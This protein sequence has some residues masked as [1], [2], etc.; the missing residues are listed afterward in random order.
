[1]GQ[2]VSFDREFYERFAKEFVDIYEQNG[3]LAAANFSLSKNLPKERYDE[4]REYIEQEF[5]GRGYKFPNKEQ[6]LTG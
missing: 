3:P 5:L 4:T 1:M 2:I 6:E